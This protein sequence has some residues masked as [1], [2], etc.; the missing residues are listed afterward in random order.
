MVDLTLPADVPPGI[1][2]LSVVTAEG[3]S[4]PVGI[5]VDGLPQLLVGDSA[6]DHPTALPAAF[7][8]LL[9]GAGQSRVYF[10][11]KAGARVVAE[12]EAKRIGS[13]MDPVLELKND[14]RNDHGDRMGQ[15]L[16]ARRCADRSDPARDGTYFVELHDLEY[17]AP[18]DSPFRLLVGDF[19]AVDQYFPAVA[20]RGSELNVEP[21]GTGLPSGTRDLR[22]PERQCRRAGEVS[23]R[24][25]E[26]STLPARCPRCGSA[27]ASRF[28][29]SLSPANSSRRSMPALPTSVT[30]PSPSTGGCRKPRRSTAI[31]WPS[32]PGQALALS[33]DGRSLNSP[34]EGEIS[35]L[36]HPGGKVLA[37]DGGT[38]GAAAKGMQY[39]VP[40]DVASVEV[41]VRDLLGRGGPHFVY[42]L[43]IAPAGRPNFSLTFLDSRLNIPRH[44]R[45]VAELRV[46][47]SGLRRPDRPEDRRGRQRLDRSPA[48]SG[49]RDQPQSA[50]HLQRDRQTAFRPSPGC[51]LWAARWDV[52]PP[53]H[54]VAVIE[55]PNQAQLAGFLDSIPVAPTAESAGA[56]RGRGV[57]PLSAQGS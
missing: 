9:S 32:R 21:V 23:R 57:A 14:R 42:R 31:S 56:D 51:G 1:Y 22:R 48:A 10:N 8:G 16:S 34:A 11:G 28:W 15:G 43:R 29:R 18:T 46:D 33:V 49:R 17:R 36:S 13:G 55:S 54:R 38:P 44:G 6:P 24:C 37:T 4:K 40:A 39:Q 35:I 2:P 3:I 26:N 27:T 41:A 47:R 50:Y 5:A 12:V 45:T 53:I 7:S 25:R 19:R 20:E 52:T 30:R